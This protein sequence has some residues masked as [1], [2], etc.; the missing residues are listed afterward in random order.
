MKGWHD[1]GV[2]VS[3]VEVCVTTHLP[4]RLLVLFQAAHDSIGK[5]TDWKDEGPR[6]ILG[7]DEGLAFVGGRIAVRNLRGE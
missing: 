5:G 6:L 1:R 3:I 7:P 4:S 2:K